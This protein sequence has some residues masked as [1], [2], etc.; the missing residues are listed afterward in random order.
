MSTKKEVIKLIAELPDSATLE[1]IMEKIYFREKVDRGFRESE[2]GP[3]FS[4][5]EAKK[6]L[7]KWL[8]R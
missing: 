3:L 1:D 8:T 4:H 2:E 7:N 5:E 6:R